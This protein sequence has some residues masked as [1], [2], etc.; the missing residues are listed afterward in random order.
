MDLNRLME[1]LGPLKN[2]MHEADA[3]RKQAKMVGRAGGGAVEVTLS[4]AL[5]VEAVR[6]AE[7]AQAA[8][9]DDVGMLEDLVLTACN[10]A[11]RQYGERFGTTPEEQ[12][13][14]SLG[15][16]DLGGLLGPLMG[17]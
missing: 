9:A 8:S 5:K 16:S 11:L 3:E 15:D 1:S 14:K 12:M 17:G 2:A 6:I 13:Q 10:D 7:A 4:G